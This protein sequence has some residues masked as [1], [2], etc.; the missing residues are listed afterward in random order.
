MADAAMTMQDARYI[1][2]VVNGNK[3]PAKRVAITMF[4]KNLF[5]FLWCFCSEIHTH[6]FAIKG[7]ATESDALNNLVW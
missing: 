5:T 7:Q 2:T 3:L 1:I 6:I 4:K